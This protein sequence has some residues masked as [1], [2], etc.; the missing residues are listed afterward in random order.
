MTEVVMVSSIDTLD[1]LKTYLV[2]LF[3]R[4]RYAEITQAVG[5]HSLLINPQYTMNDQS[6]L[7]H[8]VLNMLKDRI[9]KAKGKSYGSWYVGFP[10]VM[11]QIVTVKQ[12]V[13]DKAAAEA[14]ASYR[15]AYGPFNSVDDFFFWAL[16][17]RRLPLEQIVK[18][19]DQTTAMI[20]C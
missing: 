13:T 19:I 2:D 4:E 10:K 3:K 18:Y 8:D 17:D 1:K 15:A 6:N 12:I 16:D 14:L 9:S 5:M 11:D 20:S 7:Y